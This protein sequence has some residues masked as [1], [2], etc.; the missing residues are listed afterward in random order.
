MRIFAVLI[1][2]PPLRWIGAEIATAA[3]LQDLAAA[4]H[5]VTVLS[6]GAPH[7]YR[8]QGLRVVPL[9]ADRESALRILRGASWVVTHP[10]SGTALTAPVELCGAPVA[11]MVHSTWDHVRR[12]L[13]VRRRDIAVPNSPS[14]AAE[15]GLDPGLVVR[16][17]CPEPRLRD[18][19]GEP[20]LVGFVNG[21][22]AKGGA[23][24]EALARRGVRLLGVAGG[25]G[26][27]PGGPLVE[28]ACMPQ[29][30]PEQMLR[31]YWPRISVHAQPSLRES[32]G[33]AGV[34]ALSLGVPVAASDLPGLR[35]ALDGAG[36]DWVS[37]SRPGDP[38]GLEAS[39]ERLLGSLPGEASRRALEGRVRELRA[40][41]AADRS[42]LVA[43][44]A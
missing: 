24:L 19:V 7:P 1:D 9:P 20:G 23:S 14:T 38:V 41:A 18:G 34:E 12:A 35:D 28:A 31:D 5:D 8:W 22:A 21:S 16:P 15:L 13:A 2:F 17:P 39:V 10:Y 29:M 40:A 43:A 32:W 6:L 37:W 25:W 42:R 4:G 11:M 44:M 26:D 3:V 30:P 27:A 36:G 33:M